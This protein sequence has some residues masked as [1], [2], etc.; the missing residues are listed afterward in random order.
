VSLQQ[1]RSVVVEGPLAYRMRRVRAA[2]EGESG[3]QI[4]TLQNLTERLAGGFRHAVS[5]DE[6]EPAI[7]LAL[8]EGG[9]AEIEPIR[10]LP[11][12]VRAVA[13]TLRQ[14]WYSDLDLT[15]L[16]THSPRLADMAL[17]EDRVRSQL[18]PSALLP[19]DLRTLAID[20][21]HNAPAVLGPVRIEVVSDVA[22]IWRPLLSRL[23]SFVFVEWVSGT[24]DVAWFP[25]AIT[26]MRGPSLLP[27][28]EIA[29]CADLRSEVVEA[30]RWARELMAAE[31]ASASEIAIAASSPEPWDEH[32]LGLANDAGLPIHFSHGI[33]ALAVREG[34][35]CAALADILLNGLSQSRFQRL[36]RL[37]RGDGTPL[38]TL[39]AD[40]M[41]G[42]PADAGLLTTGQ[43]QQAL[44]RASDDYAA[45]VIPIV[46]LLARGVAAA[47][48]AGALLMRGMAAKLWADALRAVP[49]EALELSLQ[50]LR[51][52]DTKDPGN[53]VV[54]CPASHLVG[55]QRH[56]TRLLG[57]TGRS[58]P[59]Q[60][61]EEP[62]LP[63]HIVC[64]RVL[65]PISVP[66]R[67]R[68]AFEIIR[69]GARRSLVLSYS[70]RDAEGRLLA[71]S[72]LVPSVTPHRRLGRARV[73]EHAF[74][75]A[76]RLL[77]RP[78]EAQ[79]LPRVVLASCCWRDWRCGEVT[80]HDGKVRPDHP[81]ILRALS[82]VQSA[83]SLRRIIRDP[84]GFVWR[85][86][87]H[88]RST[89]EEEGLLSLDPLAFGELV[90]ELLR[91]SVDALEPDP[92]FSRA[93]PHEIEMA[94]KY[95]AAVISEEWP[96]QRAAPPALL[97]QHTVEQAS[98][99]AL[100]AL[101]LDEAFLPG[102]RSWTEVPFGQ[103]EP[104]ERARELPWDPSAHVEIPGTGIRIRGSIDRLDLRERG[105]A[106]RITD[107]KTGKMP[108][109]PERV[110]LG[111]GAELQ[112]AL[113][114]TAARHLLPE[115]R[116]IISR[117]V[118]LAEGPRQFK[119]ADVDAAIRQVAKIARVSC[120]LLTNGSA[121]AG[122]DAREPYPEFRLALPANSTGYFRW[123]QA[124]LARALAPVLGFW[125]L[126]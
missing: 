79:T 58:W 1:K 3:L 72:P 26:S 101:T 99:L 82:E 64:Q 117:L 91:R 115:A 103:A 68:R 30:L 62:L 5:A 110:V 102:T 90:H 42:L 78:D 23:C 94:L 108:K 11:G 59:R 4:F 106:V 77:A 40:W 43:W 97:W 8:D 48:Q 52:S 73:P 124:A 114:A 75:E 54:W 67:D 6:L 83:T 44:Y 69:D 10:T 92:G 85:Y 29:S 20:R 34:Q 70:R 27:E 56:W 28:P 84:L 122:Q 86:A 21:T 13:R 104:P 41:R 126:P 88:W 107:F 112:R 63:D 47:E 71:P 119:L 55:A 95:A 51:V 37:V 93:P 2:R 18:H 14:A 9:F 25:G 50:E 74:S 76:D 17:I 123:K 35:R 61:T 24:A 22:P 81:V 87:L 60:V 116:Q 66:D 105:D 31:K 49:A 33:P 111:G 89:I 12:M 80:P 96:I 109:R 45:I 36:F 65:N 39:H 16:R 19:R 32:I 15:C 125:S 46:T 100:N 53:C 118:Y 113:Y 98:S 7:R 38:D 120:T 57:M 121:L